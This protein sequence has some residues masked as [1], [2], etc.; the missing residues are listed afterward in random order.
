MIPGFY[1]AGINDIKDLGEPAGAKERAPKR[2][3]SPPLSQLVVTGRQ[4]QGSKMWSCNACLTSLPHH[5]TELFKGS[6]GAPQFYRQQPFLLQHIPASLLHLSSLPGLCPP[7]ERD[8]TV[9][10]QTQSLLAREYILSAIPPLAA[11]RNHL[12]AS[13]SVSPTL[14]FR[15]SGDIMKL[16]ADFVSFP[17]TTVAVLKE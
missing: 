16:R 5:S 17:S 12:I 9:N 1:L 4:K 11:I 7:V 2:S 8:T 15:S 3:A 6:Q 14:F 13:S 10:L